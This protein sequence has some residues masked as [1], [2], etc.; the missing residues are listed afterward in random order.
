LSGTRVPD[1]VL[2]ASGN[3]NAV[4]RVYDFKFPCLAKRREDPLSDDAVQLQLD[5]YRALGGEEE[6]AIVTPQLGINR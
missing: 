4:Q 6:P 2:H 3:P 1:V 5:K